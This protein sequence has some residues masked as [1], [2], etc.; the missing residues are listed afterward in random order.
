MRTAKARCATVVASCMVL[1]S[2]LI[3]TPYAFASEGEMPAC[4]LDGTTLVAEAS[5]EHEA[6]YQA[7]STAVEGQDLGS[8]EGAPANQDDAVTTDTPDAAID[9]APDQEPQELPGPADSGTTQVQEEEATDGVSADDA[10]EQPEEP[11]DELDATTPVEGEPDATSLTEEGLLGEDVTAKKTDAAASADDGKTEAPLEA[12]AQTFVA[13]WNKVGNSYYW[14]QKNKSGVLEPLKGWLVTSQSWDKVKRG[15][16]RYWLDKTSGALAFSKLLDPQQD[17]IDYHAYADSK[18][19][20]VRGKYTDKATGYVYLANDA[21]RLES[22]GWLVSTAYDKEIQRYWVDEK[23]HACVPGASNDGWSHITTS[24]GYV[25]RGAQKAGSVMRYANNEGRVVEGWIVTSGFGQGLQRYWQANGS[26]VKNKL[27]QTGTNAWTFA[28]PEGYVVRGKWRGA[29]GVVYI[30]DNGGK[31]ENPGWVV[32]G[33]YDNGL[34]RYWIDSQYHGAV[35]GYSADGWAHYTTAD[36]Y[37]LRTKKDTGRGY[38]YVAN[39][40]GK[41]L[42]TDTDKWIVTKEF[43]GRLERYW[44]LAAEHAVRSGFFTIDGANYFGIGGQGYV[45]RQACVFHDNTWYYGDNAGKLKAIPRSVGKIGYQVPSGYPQI[46]AYGVKL[47]SYCKAPFDY[48]MPCIIAPDATREQC[49]EAF[50]ASAARWMGT[51]WVDNRTTHPGD[52]VDC[53]GLIM[54]ALYGC[55]VSLDG[56][57]GG[58]YNPWTKHYVDPYFSNS[59]RNNQVFKPVSFSEIRRG[60]IVYYDTHVAIWL[61]DGNILEATAAFGRTTLVHSNWRA[62]GPV[63]G[64]GRPF[65]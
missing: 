58:D 48:V 18:G 8:A 37:V 20:I 56:Q 4:Q 44:A 60:D 22:P 59:W 50:I 64:V 25:L 49:V 35:P 41:L 23:V 5:D 14:Y 42:I 3:N 17:G 24:E 46:N 12:Q 45:V 30:A 38:V 27:I 39:N 61:G 65:A 32:S 16:Q 53:S 26:I 28:R 29:R 21:G 19:L 7:E 11:A 13:G 6:A 54:E 40:D 63:L 2:L 33:K 57:R 1:G 36:G 43:D 34:Q 47:P 31:L 55:G 10:T 52:T 51:R 62:Y 15:L 9:A